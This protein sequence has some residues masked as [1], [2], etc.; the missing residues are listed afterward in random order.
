[1]HSNRLRPPWGY[2]FLN[3][4]LTAVRYGIIGSGMMGQEHIRNIRLL[5]GAVVAAVADPD[6]TMRQDAQRL[7][8]DGC[9]AFDNHNE[10]LVQAD[11]DALL[12]ASPNHTHIDVLRDVM[13]TD[14]PILTEKPLATSV[15][16]GRE[17]LRLQE[18]RTAP[19]WVA[20][21]YRFMPPVARLLDEVSAGTQGRLQM[22]SIREH[23]YPFLG[24]V[25]GWNRHNANTGGTLVEKCCHHFDLMRLVAG[26]EPVRIY[27]SGGIDVN[28]LDEPHPDGAPD[29][30][31]NA[32]VIVDF[33]NGVR[34]MLD[35]CMFAE[36]AYWQEILTATG[37]EGRIEAFVPGPGRFNLDGKVRHAEIAIAD[38]ATKT[39]HREEVLV[40]ESVLA[41]GDHH[42]STFFQHQ[43]F[44]AMVRNGGE[45]DVTLEDGLK[46]VIMGAAAEQSVRTGQAITF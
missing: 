42:G 21:E 38:R 46:A 29:I 40:D 39:E 26:S 9:A 12:I 24:K 4:E 31:D 6:D 44:I 23:R 41:A 30:L 19:V 5:D 3:S 28:H 11:L 33:E 1:M 14:L 7:A 13:K 10:M 8:G 16:D 15:E 17:I 35:L 36:A 45:A 18:K 25:G 32:Y 20:M 27:A 37:D 22:F 43:K 34:G 2:Q